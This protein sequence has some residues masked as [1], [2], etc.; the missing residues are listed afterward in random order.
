M[1]LNI[2]NKEALIQF[3]NK[4]F[5]ESENRTNKNS[6][7]Q[8]VF[9][10][11][12]AFTDMIKT[13]EYNDCLD[14]N[15]FILFYKFSEGDEGILFLTKKNS[16]YIYLVDRI[17]SMIENKSN[18]YIFFDSNISSKLKSK[19]VKISKVLDYPTEKQHLELKTFEDNYNLVKQNR[20]YLIG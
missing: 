11:A 8:I 19:G 12:N 5:K 15:A 4:Y 7:P 20:E 10:K 1:I 9:I 17:I 16:I 6:F 18:R 13:K 14:K 3:H 2:Q